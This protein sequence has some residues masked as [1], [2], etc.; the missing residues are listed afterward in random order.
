MRDTRGTCGQQR[1]TVRARWPGRCIVGGPG[2]HRTSD[3]SGIRDPGSS[4][5]SPSR[6]PSRGPRT[7]AAGVTR[8][9]GVLCGGVRDEGVG[10]VADAA[11]AP[12]AWLTRAR[13]RTAPRPGRR[14]TPVRARPPV[15]AGR[16]AA[17]ASS[18]GYA[19]R[20]SRPSAPS[21]SPHSARSSTRRAP[22]AP[23]ALAVQAVQAVLAS[24]QRPGGPATQS[25][26]QAREA[27]RPREARPGFPGSRRGARLR[28]P[29]CRIMGA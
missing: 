8:G 28:R 16:S 1:T 9:A 3:G 29:A 6:W 4:G 15:R 18:P 2:G 10:C 24:P 19:T 23:A 14:P 12:G 11:A 22:S 17:A 26:P 20:S 5:A 7:T 25:A 27:R 13:L 21:R